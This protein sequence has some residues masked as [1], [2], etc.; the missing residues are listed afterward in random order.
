MTK[1]FKF[2]K[3]SQMNFRKLHKTIENFTNEF[4]QKFK[5][6]L[7]KGYVD[8]DIFRQTSGL[9]KKHFPFFNIPPSPINSVQISSS[10]VPSNC[11]QSNAVQSD[12]VN[13]Q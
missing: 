7:T 3:T 5:M 12:S 6:E 13:F 1:N 11:V 2:Q 4:D 10:P 9:I 8:I